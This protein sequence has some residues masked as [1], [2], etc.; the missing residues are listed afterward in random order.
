MQ[1][2]DEAVEADAEEVAEPSTPAA[3]TN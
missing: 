3:S 2:V 1:T